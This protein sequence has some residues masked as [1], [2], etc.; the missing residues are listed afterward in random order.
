MADW[1][2]YRSRAKRQ[3]LF[4]VR[5]LCKLYIECRYDSLLLANTVLF[6][7]FVL[8]LPQSFKMVRESI[9]YLCKEAFSQG[10]KTRLLEEDFIPL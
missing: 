3:I 4:R 10:F 2:V 7:L 6:E 5:A 1:L 8:S 9:P